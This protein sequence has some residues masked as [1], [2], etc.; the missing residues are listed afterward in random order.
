[1]DID[2]IY[3]VFNTQDLCIKYIESIRWNN[4]PVCPYCNYS[5]YTKYNYNRYHCNVCN[6]SFSVM[7]NTL[8]HKTKCELQ[9]WFVALFIVRDNE[10]ISSRKLASLIGVTKDT[11]CYMLMRIRDTRNKDLINK[12]IENV[13]C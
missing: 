6:T 1:M 5:S 9:K 7:V 10:K 2:K 12:I 11:A 13:K 4:K 3:S 8:F